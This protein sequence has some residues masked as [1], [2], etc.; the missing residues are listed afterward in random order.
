MNFEEKQQRLSEAPH[1]LLKTPLHTCRMHAC[2]T[3]SAAW[4]VAALT[5]PSCLAA[6]H[7]GPDVFLQRAPRSPSVTGGAAGAGRKERERWGRRGIPPRM[8]SQRRRTDG[9]VFT[10]AERKERWHVRAPLTRVSG[11]RAAGARRFPASGPAIT[12]VRKV[13][14]CIPERSTEAA[15]RLWSK[16]PD[17]AAAA[18]AA[19]ETRYVSSLATFLPDAPGSLQD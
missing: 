16:S 17:G 8:C 15:K 11:Q 18:A 7:F 19:A 4:C 13:A 6:S 10:C 14:D 5:A 1:F 12:C 2:S 9:R 3:C